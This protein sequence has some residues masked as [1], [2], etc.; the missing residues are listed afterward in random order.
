MEYE[1]DSD[2]LRIRCY[3]ITKENLRTVEKDEENVVLYTYKNITY[4]IAEDIETT[5]A[6][7]QNGVFE[8]QITGTVSQEEIEQMIRS[9]YGD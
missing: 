6:I 8:C 4:F 2:Y 1:Q 7:W 5:K 9:I 3:Q